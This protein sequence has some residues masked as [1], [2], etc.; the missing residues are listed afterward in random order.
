MARFVEKVALVM[1]GTS[2]IG[3]A[4]AV[5]FAREHASVVV[6][7]RRE[8]EGLETVHLVDDAGGAG[9]FVRA[10]V[11]MD[12]DVRHVIEQSLKKFGRI[13]FAFNNAGVDEDPKP[14]DEQTED[15]FD[16]IFAINVKGVWLSMKYEVPVMQK[17]GGGVIVN[18]ASVAGIRGS[19]LLPIYAASKHAVVGLTRSIALAVAPREHS[20]E[21]PLPRPD[22][23]R[24]ARP[25]AEVD[26]SET[27][28]EHPDGA[29]R[30][31]P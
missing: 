21:R 16:R 4:T 26:A 29:P 3:R 13:D 25:S 5:A 10:D 30:P 2:G 15:E 22:R 14:L 11:S 8:A 20:G 24:H 7:G 18:N 12:A 23:H 31:A 1:G 6:T 28:R 17:F 9:L 27:H 19:L